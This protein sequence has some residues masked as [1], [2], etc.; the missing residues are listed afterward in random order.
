MFKVVGATGSNF[1]PEAKVNR[2][3]SFDLMKTRKKPGLDRDSRSMMTLTGNPVWRALSRKPM[4]SSAQI[5]VGL[6][7]RKALYALT[8]GSGDASDLREL[9][10]TASTAIVLAERG[11]GEAQLADF[12]AAMQALSDARARAIKGR[13]VALT[14]IESRLV[15]DMISL[16]EQQLEV[17]EKAEVTNAIT[18]GFKRANSG[19]F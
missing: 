5:R 3:R 12:N 11:Y 1:G 16:H 4:E 2:K 8:N 14:E 15:A 7:N 19:A 13:G 6:L 17:A 9:M 18:E 10:V